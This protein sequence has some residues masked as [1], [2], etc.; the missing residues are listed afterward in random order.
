MKKF[1]QQQM[2]YFLIGITLFTL[3][4]S[5]Q[6][7]PQAES[8]SP[9]ITPTTPAATQFPPV[10]SPNAELSASPAQL[11]PLTYDYDALEKAK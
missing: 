2:S 1:L 5:C 7:T 8:Q 4:F 3:L 10:A 6:P 9:T 11:P